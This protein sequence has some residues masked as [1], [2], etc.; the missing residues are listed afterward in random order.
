M[1]ASDDLGAD[2]KAL[3]MDE[4]R[5]S[6]EVDTLAAAATGPEMAT[7]IDVAAAP[8]PQEPPGT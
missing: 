7:E 1:E 5:R 3:P 8:G 4:L 2:D 6:V